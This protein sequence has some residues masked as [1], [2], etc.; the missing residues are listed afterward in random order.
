MFHGIP[1]GQDRNRTKAMHGV[2]LDLL[3]ATARQA[4]PHAHHRAAHLAALRAARCQRWQDR[5]ARLRAVFAQR[6]APPR[7]AGPERLS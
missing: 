4:D 7:Q 1:E 5:M 6:P 2:N 3:R